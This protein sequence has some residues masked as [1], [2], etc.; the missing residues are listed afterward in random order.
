MPGQIVIIESGATKSDWRVLEK[1]GGEVR[2]FH[3]SGTNVSTMP[4]DAIKAA[5]EEAIRSEGLERADGLYLYTAGVVTETISSQLKDYIKSISAIRE[6]DVQNDLMGAARGVCGHSK[7]IVAI[8]G[9]GSNTCFFDGRFISQKVYSGGYV[10]GDDGSAAALGKLFLSDLIKGMVP[11]SIAADFARS[12]DASYAGIVE[13]V[14][15][16]GAPS[17]YL[18]SLAPFLLAHYAHPYAKDLIERNFQAFI[19]RSLRH[20]DTASFPLG[21]V[22]GFG[23][24]C[25]DIFRPLCE[26]AGIRISRF[27]QAPIDGLCQYHGR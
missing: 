11:E 15:R 16:S 9:T 3:R 14:Y 13:N 24:A 25:R 2:Q 23:W 12:F 7:G 21:I 18:G 27:L 5:L 1:E 19:D 22:G 20:Y 17:K 4:L 10:L 6:V 8:M 26:K